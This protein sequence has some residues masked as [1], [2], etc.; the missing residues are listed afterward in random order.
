MPDIALSGTT[1]FGLLP[2]ETWADKPGL[3]LQVEFD[4]RQGRITLL[5][6]ELKRMREEIVG[7]QIELAKR[8]Q[9]R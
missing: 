7:I 2:G 4:W 1:P 6:D 8:G 9:P 3:T 5:K